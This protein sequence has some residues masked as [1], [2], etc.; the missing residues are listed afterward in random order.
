MSHLD[1]NSSQ[2]LQRLGGFQSSKKKKKHFDN[3]TSD[4]SKAQCF[5]RSAPGKG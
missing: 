2:M 4:K 1:G 3:E 5:H